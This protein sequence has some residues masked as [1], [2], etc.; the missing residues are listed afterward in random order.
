MLGHALAVLLAHMKFFQVEPKPTQTIEP[1]YAR[2]IA[3]AILQWKRCPRCER[4]LST[5]PA[6][7][8][9]LTAN[10]NWHCESYRTIC[11]AGHQVFVTLFPQQTAE[12]FSKSENEVTPFLPRTCGPHRTIRTPYV[13]PLFESRGGNERIFW[14]T[15]G[16]PDHNHDEYVRYY[17][18]PGWTVRGG[19]I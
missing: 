1:F 11:E 2:E 12:M 13:T 5:E 19:V 3:T 4:H 17:E 14:R 8:E 15:C 6:H 16:I 7:L 10:R 9:F 18:K